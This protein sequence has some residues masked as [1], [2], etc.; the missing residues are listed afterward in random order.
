MIIA[1][2]RNRASKYR[3]KKQRAYSA[4]PMLTRF[5]NGNKREQQLGIRTKAE[6]KVHFYYVK[7]YVK[8]DL[9]EHKQANMLKKPAALFNFK[10][11]VII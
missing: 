8:A 6:I 2:K 1:S 3:T 7:F 5:S 9:N 4:P 11:K 10:Y